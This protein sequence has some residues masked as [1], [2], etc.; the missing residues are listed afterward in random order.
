M[1]SGPWTKSGSPPTQLSFTLP[2]AMFC[3]FLLQVFCIFSGLSKLSH[4]F[5][6]V[7][8]IF[9]CSLNQEIELIF[10]YWSSILQPFPVAELTFLADSIWVCIENIMKSVDKDGFIFSFPMWM[11]LITS[12]WLVALARAFSQVLA[13]V[14]R[15]QSLP[16][17]QSWGKS[18]QSLAIKSDVTGG[19]FCKWWMPF[20]QVRK[21]FFHTYFAGMMLDFVTYFPGSIEMMTWFLSFK[22]LAW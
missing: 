18:V 8:N 14:M 15:G 19:Q 16:Y 10:L 3:S 12:S 20:Y 7:I 22:L 4:V 17:A 1:S 2:Q 21:N 5:D 6:A 9:N 11:S 13:K